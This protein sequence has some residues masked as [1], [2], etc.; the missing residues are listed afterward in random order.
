[1]SLK[2]SHLVHNHAWPAHRSRLAVVMTAL[3]LW[4][5]VAWPQCAAAASVQPLLLAPADV[6]QYL[7]VMH[8]AVRRVR[9]PTAEDR[10]AQD[11][12]EA[13]QQR[14]RKAYDDFAAS[15][16]DGSAPS[17]E[18]TAALRASDPDPEERAAIARTATLRR[19]PDILVARELGVDER[20]YGRVRDVIERLVPEDDEDGDE[21]AERRKVPQQEPPP[22]QST[23]QEQLAQQADVR[24][25][26]TL[27]PHLKEIRKLLRQLGRKREAD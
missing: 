26:A 6:D 27:Q 14:Q 17:P 7:R 25:S 23:A 15:H 11:R 3:L 4:I 24:N 18:Q 2:T 20:H 13:A 21:D 9:H 8:A 5:G 1:M 22:R 10:A 12:A 16:A 19:Q